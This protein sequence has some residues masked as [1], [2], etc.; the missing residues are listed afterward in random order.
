[1]I[2]DNLILCFIPARGGSKRI[3]EKN[4]QLLNGKPLISYTIKSAMQ[5]HVFDRI[6]VSSDDERILKLS[7]ELM[8]GIDQR[9]E[10]L[11]DDTIKAVDV[12]MEYLIRTKAEREFKYVAL[13]LPT[14][15]FKT[16]D[17]IKN[18]VKLFE[19]QGDSSG[20]LITVTSYDFPPQL[21]LTFLNKSSCKLAMREPAQ[22]LKTTRSQDI[23]KTYHPNGALYITSIIKFLKEKTFF[24]E[25]LFGYC[26]PEER[27]FDID[28]TYQLKI[29]DSYMRWLQ[30]ESSYETKCRF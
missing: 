20:S 29:A 10:N 17:D 7:R 27:S 26:M 8:A 25:P 9:P 4:L 19:K 30:D 13:M 14:C 3:P 15:P 6:I 1:M 2:T 16:V 23:S 24:T 22:Y 18:A 5:S 28:Y 11:S 12:V 21:A